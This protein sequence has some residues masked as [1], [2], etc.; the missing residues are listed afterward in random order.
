MD[1]VNGAPKVQKRDSRGMLSEI[2]AE[3]DRTHDAELTMAFK[4]PVYVL[5]AVR[6][7]YFQF[8]VDKM[9]SAFFAEHAE[10]TNTRNSAGRVDDGVNC[11]YYASIYAESYCSTSTQC[12]APLLVLL[13]QKCWNTYCTGCCQLDLELPSCLVINTM[14]CVQMGYGHTCTDYYPNGGG[15]GKECPPNRPCQRPI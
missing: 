7:L 6:E 13:N 8:L 12:E 4:L 9:N 15:G 10:K 1:M 11:N 3:E 5:F 14:L 2:A